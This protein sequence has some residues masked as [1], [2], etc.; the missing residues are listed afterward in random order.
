MLQEIKRLKTGLARISTV[1]LFASIA[2]GSLLAADSTLSVFRDRLENDFL[3]W[4]WGPHEVSQMREIESGSAAMSFTPQ[5]YSGLYLK[6]NGNAF[7]QTTYNGLSFSIKHTAATVQQ[8][9]V[10]IGETGSDRSL[11]GMISIQPVSWQ[12]IT[13]HF[14]NMENPI[15]DYFDKIYIQGGTLGTTGT[16]YVDE[17]FLV[18]LSDNPEPTPGPA[19]DNKPVVTNPNPTGLSPAGLR[20]LS[21]AEIGLSLQDVLRLPSPPLLESFHEQTSR[22]QLYRNSL[23]TL[24]DSANLRALDREIA[25][26]VG[27]IKLS[28]L[29]KKLIGCDI[30]S[31]VSCRET[32]LQRLAIHA[33]RR[34]LTPAET[35]LFKNWAQQT[36]GMESQEF[37]VSLRS[38]LSSILYDPRFLFRS[39]LGAGGNETVRG[40]FP[41]KTWEKLTALSY[42][43]THRP[44]SMEL[45]GKLGDFETDP[46]LFPLLIRDYSHSPQLATVLSEFI[47]QWL[48]IH[49]LED[50][51][52]PGVIG[53]TPAKARAYLTEMR[54]TIAGSL[55][56]NGSLH[57]LI[58]EP[59]LVADNN[60]FGIFGSRAFL[61]ASGKNGKPS[62][63]F[64]GVRILRY[65]L[66]QN[67]PPP[68][69]TIDTT[70]PK[71]LDPNDP[72]Y[73]EKLTLQHGARPT[74]KGCH[75]RIDSIGLALQNFDGL[76][77]SRGHK[78]DFEALGI[79][80]NVT[81][82]LAGLT[83][84]IVTSS[85]E[86]FADSLGESTVFQR[87][88][89]RNAMRYATGRELSDKEVNLA[90]S[91]AA[92][93]LKEGSESQDNIA[94][95]FQALMMRDDLY[96]RSA[97]ANL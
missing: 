50:Q 37:T 61:T 77:A 21:K 52:M 12:K 39:E 83:E 71:D 73:D 54:Q 22:S 57:A 32:F 33:W 84:S 90:D 78:V 79:K 55:V 17:I 15:G 60:G 96:T 64:R 80:P 13:I 97:V 68:P 29:A 74:C 16:F 46:N 43:L 66:C 53:W 11:S 69:P 14:R 20:P 45:I 59:N 42:T 86:A 38:A 30:L 28:D 23:S 40:S 2:H 67:L 41:L 10:G 56:Q 82:S 44:P 19:P 81:V 95:F 62:M 75:S 72:N 70:A 31:L 87:C 1:F 27:S 88:F 24:N 6:K 34:P 93:Y 26:L 76:G 35:S 94:N 36:N 3:D 92:Q 89:A 9:R 85:A 5:N 49:G 25:N 63:I 18:K 58:T 65:A 48:M 47:S 91:L 4:S 8:I 51:S 7:S